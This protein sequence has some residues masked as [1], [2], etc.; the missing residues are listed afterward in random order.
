[1]RLT[2]G[3][4]LAQLSLAN[5][6]FPKPLTQLTIFKKQRPRLQGIELP[7]LLFA[8]PFSGRTR[9]EQSRGPIA[10][11]PGLEKKTGGLRGP[12]FIVGGMILNRECYQGIGSK[13]PPENYAAKT[14]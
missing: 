5:Q 3:I 13:K 4:L 10:P 11:E 2:H 8:V 9:R 12:P 6:F 14:K 1:L 7:C